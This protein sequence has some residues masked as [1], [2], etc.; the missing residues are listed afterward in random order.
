MIKGAAKGLSGLPVASPYA[1]CDGT[2]HNNSLSRYFFR[3]FVRHA[4]SAAK[5]HITGMDIIP[6]PKQ[7]NKSSAANESGK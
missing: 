1:I 3:F 7:N 4:P 6:I 2:A 5:K